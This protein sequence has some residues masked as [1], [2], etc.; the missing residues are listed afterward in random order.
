MKTIIDTTD[1]KFIGTQIEIPE[2]G[3]ILVLGDCE[4]RVIAV[5]ETRIVCFNYVVEVE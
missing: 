3:G 5:T 1:N 2:V 4:F